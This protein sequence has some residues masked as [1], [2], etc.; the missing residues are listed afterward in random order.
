M[1]AVTSAEGPGLVIVLSK[2]NIMSE[3]NVDGGQMKVKSI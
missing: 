2:Q 3:E 1:P